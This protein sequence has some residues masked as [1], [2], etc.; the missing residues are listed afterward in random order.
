MIAT[1]RITILNA[2]NG[3]L[4]AAR[5]P[6]GSDCSRRAPES[7]HN[8]D[9]R[10][11]GGQPSQPSRARKFVPMP[12]YRTTAIVSYFGHCFCG[13][14]RATRDDA[15]QK[16]LVLGVIE[17]RF[18]SKT[19]GE[20]SFCA[21]QRRFTRPRRAVSRVRSYHVVLARYRRNRRVFRRSRPSSSASQ[22]RMCTG[23]RRASE[24]TS[25]PLQTL[26]VDGRATIRRN[27]SAPLEDQNPA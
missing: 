18:V 6:C 9:Q 26:S 14:R 15:R 13:V 20:R 16:S 22:R 5:V 8:R 19:G 10:R 23:Q 25:G 12:D 27:S 1:L 17:G 11:L 2:A 21:H 4:T 24:A 3:I 7:C